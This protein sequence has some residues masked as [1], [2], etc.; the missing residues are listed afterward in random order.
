MGIVIYQHSMHGCP[1]Y[2]RLRARAK[3]ELILC[4]LFKEELAK[5]C[6][7]IQGAREA[8]MIDQSRGIVMNQIRIVTR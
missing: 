3:K 2:A 7:E 1:D 8:G 5:V 6:V 4:A